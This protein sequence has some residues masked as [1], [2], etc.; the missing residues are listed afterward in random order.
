MEPQGVY[1]LTK[2]HADEIIKEKS[3]LNSYTYSILRPSNIVGLKMPNQS[4]G[5]LLN[6][7]KNKRFF[8][9]GSK[10]SISTYIHVDDVVDAI[11]I[12]AKDN[13]AKNQVFNLSNDCPLTDIV[14][15][16]SNHYGFTDNFACLPE[17]LVRFTVFILNK[18]IRFP[19]NKSRIDALTSKTTYPTNKIENILGFIP[20]RPI[21]LFAVEYLKKLN[22]K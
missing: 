12:C 17:S 20:S 16:V 11:L 3:I 18:F 10:S 2:I 9:I 19:L 14:E 21:S 4:F 8:Y 5:Q 6:A 1:K 7:I 15:R 13:K 22:E